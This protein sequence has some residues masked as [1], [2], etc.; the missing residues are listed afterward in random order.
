MDYS[1]EDATMQVVARRRVLIVK[2]IYAFPL[3][4]A[5][6]VIGLL[7][8]ADYPQAEISNGRIRATLNLPDAQKG[9]YRGT[10][11]DWSGV[12]AKLEY[13]GH[14]YFEPFYE[15][16]DP[17]VRDVDLKNGVVAGPISATSGPVEEF[18]GA[19]GTTQ[20]FADAKA[21]GTFIKI[22]I[23]VLRKPDDSKYDHYYRYEIVDPGK[24][25]V[26]KGSGSVQFTQEVSDHASGYGYVYRKTVRLV[27]GQPEMLLE[28]SLKNTGSKAIEGNVYNHNFFVIDHQ[29]PGPDFTIKF[30]FPLSGTHEMTSLAEVHGNQINYLKALEN[31]DT[32]ATQI[33]G[34]GD[35]AKDY[36]IT[37]ENRKT[38]AGVHVT[39]DKPLSRVYLWSVKTTLCPEAYIDL[40]IQPG[41][42]SKWNVKYQFYTQKKPD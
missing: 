30:P 39:G 22:G 20:G 3:V 23:G 32:A 25:T 12:I 16:F 31:G 8:A 28:H 1:S 35:T 40:H 21:G 10:R 27:K 17:D 26:K 18:G 37:V 11:F 41:Q 33:K 4:A 15:K 2:K 9:Y 7:G 14:T 24:W 34:F 42:E 38:G 13:D 5:V 19:D 36:D 6:A 29:P